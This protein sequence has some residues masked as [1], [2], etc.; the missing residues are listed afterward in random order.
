MKKYVR[1]NYTMSDKRIE[2]AKRQIWMYSN[3]YPADIEILDAWETTDDGVYVLIEE[4]GDKYVLRCYQG[5][6]FNV[7]NE[8]VWV[9]AKRALED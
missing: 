1:A 4:A 7:N 6:I 9:A 3:E 8:N 5:G 2:D